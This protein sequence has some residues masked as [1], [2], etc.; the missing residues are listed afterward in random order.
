[1][2]FCRISAENHQRAF[3]R[4]IAFTHTTRA[5]A[6]GELHDVAVRTRNLVPFCVVSIIWLCPFS[7]KDVPAYLVR[8]KEIQI[9]DAL[10]LIA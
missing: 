10:Y 1:L 7:K 2:S 6:D 3:K 4:A 8:G 9:V 5:I